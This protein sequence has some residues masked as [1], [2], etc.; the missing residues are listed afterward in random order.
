L[1]FWAPRWEALFSFSAGAVLS[2]RH[3]LPAFSFALFRPRF[4]GL[5]SLALCQLIVAA[6]PHLTILFA[7]V[8]SI[9]LCGPLDISNTLYAYLSHS[10][11]LLPSLILSNP[12]KSS[13]ILSNPL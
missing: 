5:F 8:I 2:V 6:L 10:I 12:L 13:L 7:L 1:F 4:F 3:V 9:F 11:S